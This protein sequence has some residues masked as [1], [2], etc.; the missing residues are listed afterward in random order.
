MVTCTIAGIS[1]HSSA[2]S[3]PA[4]AT[5]LGEDATGGQSLVDPDGPR[6]GICVALEIKRNS[7]KPI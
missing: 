7:G 6:N 5:S 2:A 4:S 1:Q 3:N